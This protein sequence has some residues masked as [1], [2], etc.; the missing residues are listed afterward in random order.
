MAV[1]ELN[2]AS[3]RILSVAAALAHS[4]ALLFPGWQPPLVIPSTPLMGTQPVTAY[5]ISN[6]DARWEHAQALLNSCG[7]QPIRVRPVSLEAASAALERFSLPEIHRDNVRMSNLL[8]QERIATIIADDASLGPSGY[9]L[10]F[11][12]DVDLDES[13]SP[14]LVPI[15]VAAT[16]ESTFSSSDGIF[17]L[18]LCGT[19]CSHFQRASVHGVLFARCVSVCAHAY[20][21]MKSH[22]QNWWA[23]MKALAIA[24]CQRQQRC[25]RFHVSAGDVIIST[26]FAGRPMSKWPI[27]VGA[28][29]TTHETNSGLLGDAGSG[30]F[31]QA[32]S[33]FPSGM[34]TIVP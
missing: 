24:E 13:V 29:L 28:N 1:I 11:E 5:V 10:V 34:R 19:P 2:S 26:V 7:L 12:D 14:L 8:T 27:L 20:G 33:K 16:A 18:G 9:S 32:N 3:V 17:F 4:S 22:A 23:T 25:N 31:Y 30:L 21:L 6:D 15:L